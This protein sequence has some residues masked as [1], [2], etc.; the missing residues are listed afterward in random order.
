MG[1]DYFM[2]GQFDLRKVHIV[3]DHDARF[4]DRRGQWDSWNRWNRW[5][6]QV[7]SRQGVHIEMRPGISQWR[8]V[9]IGH[10]Q[11]LRLLRIGGQLEKPRT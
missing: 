4:V 11:Q 8:G 9:D 2:L 1:M 3:I 10:Q 5:V 6:W 7:R